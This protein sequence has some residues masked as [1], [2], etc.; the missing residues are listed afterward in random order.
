MFPHVS[1]GSAAGPPNTRRRSRG[2]RT[3]PCTALRTR[4]TKLIKCFE[5]I[6]PGSRVADL[7]L[8][9]P[10]GYLP[11]TPRAAVA[12]SRSVISD[13][14]VCRVSVASPSQPPMSGWARHQES[15]PKPPGT[16]PSTEAMFTLR[17]EGPLPLAVSPTLPG[18]LGGAGVSSEVNWEWRSF[19]AGGQGLDQ[20][21]AV[22]VAEGSPKD[23]PP[24]SDLVPRQGVGR[25]CAPEDLPSLV[26]QARGV[27]WQQP[28]QS[29]LHHRS[30]AG[31]HSVLQPGIPPALT[32]VAGR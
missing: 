10:R 17:T 23:V 28:E 7:R 4:F 5:V 20:V 3:S 27:V 25:R 32:D 22:G 2:T 8:G 15:P 29:R 21:P 6:V 31:R 9:D 24:L 12:S 26:E 30:G 11:R 19:Q 14:R 1:C 16:A 18:G 13:A